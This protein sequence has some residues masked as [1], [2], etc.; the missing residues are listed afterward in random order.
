MRPPD[1]ER[2]PPGQ[3]KAADQSS[4]KTAAAHKESGKEGAGR[5]NGLALCSVC[6]TP[7][8]PVLP[9]NAYATHPMCDPSEVSPMWPPGPISERA[10]K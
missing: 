6:R 1:K 7:M 10:I 8:A 9:A 3:E 5:A 2:R 4:V